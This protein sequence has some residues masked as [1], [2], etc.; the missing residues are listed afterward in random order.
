VT[1]FFRDPEAFQVLSREAIPQMISGKES[2][3]TIRIWVPGCSTGQEAYSIAIC[4]S[5]QLRSNPLHLGIR[6][7][8]T[9]IKDSMVHQARLGLYPRTIASQMSRQRLE[10]FLVETPHGYQISK[11]VREMCIFARQ[12][13]LK[14]PPFA[15][16]DLL[17]CRNLLMYLEPAVQNR[18]IRLFDYALRPGGVLFLGRSEMPSECNRYF[19]LLDRRWKIYRK[20]CISA[21]NALESWA[22]LSGVERNWRKVA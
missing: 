20:M 16:L 1:T 22:L 18:L 14:D 12:N 3:E 17:S 4:L 9:D 21:S 19:Q 15:H 8:A 2:G 7:F 5:E 13:V 11:S 6:I 10:R